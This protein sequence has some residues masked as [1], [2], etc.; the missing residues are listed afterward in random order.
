VLGN[1]HIYYNRPP[2]SADTTMDIKK[3]TADQIDTLNKISALMANV[4]ANFDEL[5]KIYNEKKQLQFSN[6]IE[7]K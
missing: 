5:Q 7:D 1:E 6:P 2:I 4:D 3:L